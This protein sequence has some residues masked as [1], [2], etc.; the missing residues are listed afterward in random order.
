[1]TLG[2][3]GCETLGLRNREMEETGKGG[4]GDG[5]NGLAREMLSLIL[6]VDYKK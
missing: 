6:F 5:E 1:M 2:L 3:C 4:I